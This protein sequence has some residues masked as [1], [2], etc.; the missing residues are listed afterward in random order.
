MTNTKMNTKNH[1]SRT[2]EMHTE[3][4]GQATELV[5]ILDRSGSMS[6]YEED[7]VGG[8]NATIEQQRETPGKCFVSAYL[9]NDAAELV[10]DRKE[11][12]DVRKMEKRDYR[13][14]GCT[15]LIDAIGGGIRHIEEI[16]RY[17]RKEAIP[18]HTI[19]VIMTD[20]LENASHRFSSDE[21]KKLI[22]AKKECGWEFLFLGANIDAV[23][24]A[25]HFGIREDRV[26]NYRQDSAGYKAS[27]KSVAKAVM[28]MRVC[29]S[30]AEDWAQEVKEDYR[31]DR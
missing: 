5:F 28:S 1:T 4:S 8:F 16:H 18:A 11:L 2:A 26:A 31:K 9:F 6:G 25:K 21:V 29:G 12:S 13:V 20:G 22:A 19:F 17:A 24:T 14:G 3:V 30:V 10:I 23:E 7:A 27:S 15:A